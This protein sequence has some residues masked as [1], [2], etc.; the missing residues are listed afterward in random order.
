MKQQKGKQLAESLIRQYCPDYKFKFND[1]YTTQFGN[2]NWK[3]KTISLSS[4]LVKLNKEEQIRNAILHEIAHAITPQHGHDKEWRKTA[5][6]IGCIGDRCYSKEVVIPKRKEYNYECPNCKK[7]SIRH[8]RSNTIACRNCCNK[9]NS[10]KYSKDFIF[11]LV[12]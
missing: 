12:K 5:V 6:S 3:T 9:Y 4:K 7:I 11:K 8:I 10:G 1:R 2:C